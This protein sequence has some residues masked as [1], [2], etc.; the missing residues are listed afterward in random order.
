[1]MVTAA[2]LARLD[3][4]LDSL[5]AAIEVDERLRVA[6]FR[7][8]TREFALARH[9]ELRPDH[10]GRLVRW[11]Y[12]SEKRCHMGEPFAVHSDAEI[13]AV[14]ERIE[15]KGRGKT[16]GERMLPRTGGKPTSGLDH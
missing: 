1:L 14:I 16:V 6:V 15:A 10:A 11:E 3:A 5:A 8:E 4:K 13:R 9:R 2:Q 7:D 12:R